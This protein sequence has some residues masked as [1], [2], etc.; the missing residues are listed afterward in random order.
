MK[1]LA[2]VLI[3][4]CVVKSVLNLQCLSK[5]SDFYI[6][7]SNRTLDDEYTDCEVG[8]K[9]IEINN[10][11]IDPNCLWRKDLDD[12]LKTMNTSIHKIIIR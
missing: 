6:E 2:I 12:F 1:S 5:S 11:Y 3:A 10:L 8:F 7:C 9:D 4:F